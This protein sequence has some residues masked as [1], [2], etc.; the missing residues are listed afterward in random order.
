ML[1]G[2]SPASLGLVDDGLATVL[3][4]RGIAAKSP[5]DDQ[6]A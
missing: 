2:A 1:R 6:S 3:Q 4:Q 5:D